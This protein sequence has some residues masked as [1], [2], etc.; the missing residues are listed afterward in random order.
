[1][2]RGSLRHYSSH[3]RRSGL[4]WDT[5]LVFVLGAIALNFLGLY[6]THRALIATFEP[7]EPPEPEDD[8]I[9][10]GYV[11]PSE[12][13]EPIPVA[14]DGDG[15]RPNDETREGGAQAEPDELGPN[16]DAPR[17]TS[18]RET[19]PDDDP[20]GRPDAAGAGDERGVGD[21][22]GHEAD[23]QLGPDQDGL[24]TAPDGE[25][26]GSGDAAGGLH[27][28]SDPLA[29]LGGSPS[30]LDQTFGRPPPTDRTRGEGDG[31][32]SVLDNREQVYGSF[33][34]RMRDRLY[35]H[36]RARQVV[37]RVDP[38]GSTYGA[39]RRTTVLKVRIDDD[40]KI[41]KI[42]IAQPSGFPE[43]DEEAVRTMKAAAPFPNPPSG[44][45]DEDGYID[46]PFGFIVDRQG[47]PRIFRFGR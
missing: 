11:N 16:Q 1:M 29:N 17:R 40:G 41:V 39:G 14:D 37:D 44:L 35:E 36:W 2:P 6:L 24:V 23:E 18:S 20:A 30:V 38:D 22:Q 10:F 4:A 21:A 43:L 3:G 42:V 32:S 25:L 31:V 46:F 7:Y 27:G 33:F 5:A 13:G 47:A 28:K 19:E 12:L 8:V 15:E 45:A 34:N 9:A 26:A